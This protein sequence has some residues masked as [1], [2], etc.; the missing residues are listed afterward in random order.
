M[1]K[2]VFSGANLRPREAVSGTEEPSVTDRSTLE[3]MIDSIYEDGRRYDSLFVG[4]GADIAFWVLELACGTGKYFLPTSAAGIDIVGLDLSE[5]MLN[6]AHRKLGD[7]SSPK[8]VCSDMRQFVLNRKFRCVLIARDSLCHLLTTSDLESCLRLTLLYRQRA[9]W[10]AVLARARVAR[11]PSRNAHGAAR[12]AIVTA[13]DGPR[14]VCAHSGFGKKTETHRAG[15]L[16][17][18]YADPLVLF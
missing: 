1:H 2:G 4:S 3:E 18:R 7:G 10:S 6:E 8:L 11:S 5:A 9:A 16:A 13:V 12:S 14:H 17:V 15:T